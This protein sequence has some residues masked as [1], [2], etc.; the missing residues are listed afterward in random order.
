[1][2]LRTAPPREEL[3][4][5]S[6]LSKQSGRRRRPL[7][8]NSQEIPSLSFCNRTGHGET[9]VLDLTASDMNS[10]IHQNLHQIWHTNLHHQS[11]H[12]K[13]RELQ[14]KPLNIPWHSRRH[15]Y[16]SQ[17]SV[18]AAI[19]AGGDLILSPCPSS[20]GREPPIEDTCKDLCTEERDPPM[21]SEIVAPKRW[22]LSF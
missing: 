6:T 3:S 5:P 12:A 21:P 20:L 2:I 8:A 18:Q 16:P 15:E 17:A 14:V 7:P 9:T 11:P 13:D 1:M 22:G 19:H 4:E 10:S